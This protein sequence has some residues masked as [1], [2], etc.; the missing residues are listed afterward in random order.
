MTADLFGGSGPATAI[1]A[2]GGSADELARQFLDVVEGRTGR[3]AARSGAGWVVRC[4][5]HED[6]NPSLSVTI[7][8]DRD[9][10]LVHC[11]A[12]CSPDD[13]VTAVGW[14]VKELFVQ[15]APPVLE[16]RPVVARS[17]P[18]VAQRSAY[19]YADELG[20]VLF[21]VVVER[22]PSGA[23][24]VYQHAINPDGSRAKTLGN[25]RRVLYRLPQVIAAV[26]VGAPIL[27]VEGEKCVEAVE[28]SL[29][30]VATTN[31]GGAGKW[32]PEYSE[33]LTGAVVYVLADNDQ[34]G[35]AHAQ[36]V[37]EALTGV[38]RS[39]R[40][41][42]LPNLPEHGDVADWVGAG[43]TRERLLALL[44]E[45]AE[46]S[47]IHPLPG[48][49]AEEAT[50]PAPV[51]SQAAL[52]GVFGQAIELLD[53]CTEAEP[54]AILAHL[55]VGFGVMVGPRPF[56]RVGTQRMPAKT[57]AVVVGASAK[58]RKGTAWGDAALILEHADDDFLR[59]QQVTGLA[60]G[61]GLIFRL[62]DE[63][64]GMF[65]PTADD[66]ERDAALLRDPRLLIVEPEWG[67]VL[68]L[69]QRQGN[70]L[71]AV[72]REAWD[73]GP[74]QVMTKHEPMRAS[75]HHVGLVGHVTIDELISELD[76]TSAANGFANRHLF[77]H[78][79]RRKVLDDPPQPSDA[80]VGV[81]AVQLRQAARAARERSEIRLSVSARAAWKRMYH[82]MEDPSRAEPAGIAAHLLQRGPAQVLRMALI[83]AL[84][85]QAGEITVEHLNAAHAV[86]AYSEA[87]VLHVF[88][89]RLGD[90]VAERLLRAVRRAGVGGLTGSQ[91]YDALDRN[92]SK[93]ALGRA[94]ALLVRFGLAQQ[95]I[96][97]AGPQGGRPSSVLI[98][99]Q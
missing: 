66:P 54:A 55:L 74:L 99:R 83:Y 18:Q 25:A 84:A 28:D 21:E 80:G 96:M 35:R 1:G 45:S 4:P 10:V 78:V 63:D 8:R 37:I 86:W 59:T 20:T 65:E 64:K 57:F 81:V 60:S 6:A 56:L 87:S 38:A 97:P 42:E 26:R 68:R 51:L 67:K 95:R 7:G 92:V 61:E 16:A 72:I 52:H 79:T 2:H 75:L 12:G 34:P 29:G 5:A 70:T 14:Q 32:R 62:R 69:N 13:V 48:L 91:Q 17:R 27:V 36:Q 46:V 77:L 85:D 53:P 43:G 31:P 15:E 58:A 94:V 19:T 41:I 39:V 90:P 73:T 88:G 76:S 11:H 30:L 23:K 33:C 71:S 49:P 9:R 22:Q 89:H 47:P 44:N 50:F 98:S 93:E 82:R 3:S 24:K 40:A